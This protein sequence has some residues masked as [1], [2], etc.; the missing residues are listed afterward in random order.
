MK[1]T[2]WATPDRSRSEIVVTIDN[3]LEIGRYPCATGE[4]EAERAEFEKMLLLVR[5]EVLTTVLG[6]SE[7]FLRRR[8]R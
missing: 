5:G 6:G 7:S 8:L 4:P 1:V 2:L 3:G